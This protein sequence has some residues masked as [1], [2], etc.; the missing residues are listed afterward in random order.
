MITHCTITVT[1]RRKNVSSL[2]VE[3]CE[4]RRNQRQTPEKMSRQHKL[5]VSQLHRACRV[6]ACSWSTCLPGFDSCSAVYAVMYNIHQ[7]SHSCG[8]K[9][10]L[11]KTQFEHHA[12]TSACSTLNILK[13]H[14]CDGNTEYQSGT[15]GNYRSKHHE[16]IK[17]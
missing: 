9:Y 3:A 12:S 16:S 2:S 17:V 1:L 7:T 8:G 15:S 14:I 6:P 4:L 5:M 11:C 10:K 13:L